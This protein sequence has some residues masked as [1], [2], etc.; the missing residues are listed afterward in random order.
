M[1][2]W[3]PGRLDVFA[4]GADSGLWHQWHDNGWSGWQ[5]LGGVL[6]SAPAAATSGPGRLHVF[7]RGADSGLWHQGFD[8]TAWSGWESLGGALTSAPAAASSGS[9]RLHVFA[10]GL[11][12]AL[13]HRSFDGTA[14]SGWESL[15]GALTSAPAV[16]SWGPGRLD[17]FA[18]GLDSALWH[19]SFDGASWSGWEGLGGALTSAPAV[20]SWGLGR[21]DV[22]AA[23]L[24]SALWHR[25]FEGGWGGW[26][27][28]GGLLTSGPA[29]AS[30]G[31]DRIDVFATGTDSALWHRWWVAAPAPEPTPPAA[32]PTVRVHAKILTA[33]D[34]AVTD[35]IARM[36]EVY[37]TVGIAVE[38]ASTE[39]LDLPTLNDVDVGDCIRGQTTAEQGELFAHRSGAGPN[40]VVVYF[41][42][43]TVPPY[44]GC[45]T[46][47]AGRPGAVVARG[48]TQWTLGHEVGHVL[49]LGHVGS[50]DSL[51]TG[52][53]TS[54][55]TNPPPDLS[56]G[57]G[58]TML[59][60]PFSQ[61]V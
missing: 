49:G 1:T 19:R 9:G 26:E 11:D 50:R 61:E 51:M 12:S 10:R 46:F 20:A 16:A 36:R 22:F 40:D 17:V 44:N 52:G 2:S 7:A 53:G 28:L 34:V 27:S 56:P 23:G 42:R 32:M 57:E 4:R 14:W 25:T 31:R 59:S 5:P 8:G 45:A 43:S 60:S 3:T 21:L 39:R 18:A 15:G 58:Q 35:A 41:V 54:N 55:I 24:D 30:W 38:L 33:P 6:S 47:P 13:W 48:A 29:A 37:A